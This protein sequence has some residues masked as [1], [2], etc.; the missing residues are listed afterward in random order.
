[1]AKRNLPTPL[2]NPGDEVFI[3]C[4]RKGLGIGNAVFGKIFKRRWHNGYDYWIAFQPKGKG[5][6][7]VK[8]FEGHIKPRAEYAE[9]KLEDRIREIEDH[10]DTMAAYHL[11]DQKD[12]S[13]LEIK[14]LKKQIRDDREELKR[15]Q[16]KLKGINAQLK[17]LTSK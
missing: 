13:I 12:S 10:E 4:N 17:V 9:W 2:F 15:L 16:A 7:I 14:R 5:Q 8:I 11:R 6:V 1:M 3:E